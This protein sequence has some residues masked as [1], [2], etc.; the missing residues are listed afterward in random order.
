MHSVES[1]SQEGLGDFFAN[2]YLLEGTESFSTG[3]AVVVTLQDCR[4]FQEYLSGFSLQREKTIFRN[5]TFFLDPVCMKT[6]WF[7]AERTYLFLLL[8]ISANR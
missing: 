1:Y 6:V 7:W 4:G 8:W 3:S 5:T 2:E